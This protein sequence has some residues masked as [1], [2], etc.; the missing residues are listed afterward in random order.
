[1]IHRHPP[2]LRNF[3]YLGLYYYSLTW[4]CF[5]RKRLF[6]EQDRVDLGKQ[7]SGVTFSARFNESLLHTMPDLL[8]MGLCIVSL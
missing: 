6:R 2:P 5:E 4:C 7:Y 3:G 1:M 8:E